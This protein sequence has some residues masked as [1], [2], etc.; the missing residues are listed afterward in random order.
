MAITL[1]I[2]VS[3][4]LLCPVARKHI[5]RKLS[6]S[7]FAQVLFQYIW[8]ISIL[9]RM[10]DTS[11]CSSS[12]LLSSCWKVATLGEEG[13]RREEGMYVLGGPG[14]FHQLKLVAWKFPIPPKRNGRLQFS[15]DRTQVISLDNHV[16]FLPLWYVTASIA[17]YCYKTRG[18]ETEARIEWKCKKEEMENRTCWVWHGP[19][20]TEAMMVEY[21]DLK[22]NGY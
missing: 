18:K 20:C 9:H 8:L 17:V 4:P 1:N 10:L 16:S 6:P 22:N 14:V 13:N 3:C 11:T 21:C 5:R 12:A 19:I 7:N 2:W 15:R